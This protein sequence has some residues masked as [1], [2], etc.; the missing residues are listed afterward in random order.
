MGVL[1]LQCIA[2]STQQWYVYVLTQIV[3]ANEL[4]TLYRFKE[5]RNKSQ[6]LTRYPGIIINITILAF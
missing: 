3:Y 6:T 2:L 1:F 5:C 4:S